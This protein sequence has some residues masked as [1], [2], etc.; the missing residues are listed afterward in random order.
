MCIALLDELWG[1][2]ASYNCDGKMQN[3]SML[4]FILGAPL[5]NLPGQEMKMTDLLTAGFKKN[6][7]PQITFEVQFN[8][9]KTSIEGIFSKNFVSATICL[10][11]F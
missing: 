3:W 10:F 9:R 6:L 8:C 2:T 4:S 1:G 7:D 5:K 11:I